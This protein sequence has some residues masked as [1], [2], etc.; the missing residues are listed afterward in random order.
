MMKAVMSELYLIYPRIEC[1]L[2]VL[3]H[4]FTMWNELTELMVVPL[5]NIVEKCV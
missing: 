2:T 3:R 5:F 4:V 1:W